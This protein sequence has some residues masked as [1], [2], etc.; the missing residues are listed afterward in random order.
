MPNKIL[1]GLIVL[2]AIIEGIFPGV[3]PENILPLALVVLGIVAAVLGDDSEHPTAVLVVAIAA[4]AA[5]GADVLNNVH[6]IGAYLDRILDAL[7]IALLS[8]VVAVVAMRIWNQLT[9]SD[10]SE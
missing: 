6:V 4:A 3:V 1:L 9:A 7:V 2:A 10:D 5:S 8:G